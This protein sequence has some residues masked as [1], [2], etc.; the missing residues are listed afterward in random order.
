MSQNNNQ[1]FILW[2]A[3]RGSDPNLLKLTRYE[4]SFA[5]CLKVLT[6]EFSRKNM[7]YLFNASFYRL[8]YKLRISLW[9]K[10]KPRWLISMKIQWCKQLQLLLIHLLPT[11]H[12]TGKVNMGKTGR[13]TQPGVS[14]INNI[15]IHHKLM[16][17]IMGESLINLD[18]Y[19]AYFDFLIELT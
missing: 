17:H 12:S 16:L 11:I 19:M 15:M 3:L 7:N 14:T 5:Y 2:L 1:R 6:D 13:S 18:P 9:P 8:A 4:L 10:W